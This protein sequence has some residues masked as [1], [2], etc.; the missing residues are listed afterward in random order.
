MVSD[1]NRIKT[2]VPWALEGIWKLRTGTKMTQNALLKSYP[3]G[4]LGRA[5]GQQWET[6]WSPLP[7]SYLGLRLGTVCFS[8]KKQF[9]MSFDMDLLVG[10]RLKGRKVGEGRGGKRKAMAYFPSFASWLAQVG[11]NPILSGREGITIWCVFFFFFFLLVNVKQFA[12]ETGG[13]CVVMDRGLK[14]TGIYW[15]TCL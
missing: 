10:L 13:A 2:P 7:L 11:E 4:S 9:W 8:V 5:W 3:A 15:E 1:R 6:Y 12:Q 14:Y